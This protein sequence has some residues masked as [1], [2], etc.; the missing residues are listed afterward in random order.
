MIWKTFF[1]CHLFTTIRLVWKIFQIWNLKLSKQFWY[2][3][4]ECGYAGVRW[5]KSKFYTNSSAHYFFTSLTQK[6]VELLVEIRNIYGY[7]EY[8]TKFFLIFRFSQK[9]VC[10]NLVF[11]ANYCFTNQWEH[12]HHK[13]FCLSILTKSSVLFGTNS[14]N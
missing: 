14:Q 5:V 7:K 9:V 8:K 4:K 1:S 12:F 6:Q 3:S 13:V 10:I 11:E 2:S